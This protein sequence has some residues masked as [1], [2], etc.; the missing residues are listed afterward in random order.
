MKRV[1]KFECGTL[2]E[3][4]TKKF[5]LTQEYEG[6]GIYEEVSPNGYR[7]N[8]SWLITN[9]KIA[10]ICQS[11]NCF[12]KEELLDMIDNYNE[13]KIFGIKGFYKDVL[14]NLSIYIA[15]SGYK[16]II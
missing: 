8:Q 15:H 6:F 13:E 1:I 14:N 7:V 3:L 12:C 5:V 10:L 16:T 4:N 2:D 11:Y 9:D